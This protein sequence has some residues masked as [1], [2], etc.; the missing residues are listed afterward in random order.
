MNIPIDWYYDNRVAVLRP[1][2]DV[3]LWTVHFQQVVDNWPQGQPIF[4]LNDLSACL[5]PHIR[6][7]TYEN[8]A[9]IP[10]GQRTYI[11]IVVADDMLYRIL[12]VFTRRTVLSYPWLTSE[13]F[14][15]RDAALQW[16]GRALIAESHEVI[17]H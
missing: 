16:L 7:Q 8:I 5:D 4:L 6:Q 2:V 15:S 9:H 3:A 10:R 11:A 1:H 17:K 14:L 13:V 12:N